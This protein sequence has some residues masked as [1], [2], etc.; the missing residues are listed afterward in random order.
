[1]QIL[2]NQNQKKIIQLLSEN[3]NQVLP[4]QS[5][6]DTIGVTARTLRTE[7]KKINDAI[8]ETLIISNNRGYQLKYT[9]LSGFSFVDADLSRNSQILFYLLDH[10]Q[11]EIDD[12]AETIYMS[13]S[14]LIQQ[15]PE[16]SREL[17]PLDL[18]LERRKN[19]LTVAGTEGNLRDLLISLLYKRLSS[20]IYDMDALSQ[21]C[22][23]IDAR[24]LQQTLHIVLEAHQYQA[25]GIYGMNLNLNLTVSFSRMIKGFRSD[26]FAHDV[27]M[28]TEEYHI[29]E[30]F[31]NRVAEFY[32]ISLCREDYNYV[33]VLMIGQ[34]KPKAGWRTL[35]GE[36]SSVFLNETRTVLESA[37]QYLNL[38]IDVSD[39]Q[40]E[41]SDYVYFMM[42]RCRIKNYAANQLAA[43][44]RINCPFLYD[45]AVRVAHEYR[46]R[47]SIEPDDAEIALLMVHM[48]KAVEQYRNQKKRLGVLLI[49]EA[50][51]DSVKEE[52]ARLISEKYK[53]SVEKVNVSSFYQVETMERQPD[54]IISTI[55]RVMPG[56]NIVNIT[57]LLLLSDELKLNEKIR[58]ILEEQRKKHLSASMRRYMKKTVF[59]KNVSCSTEKEAVEVMSE[60]GGFSNCAR[61]VEDILERESLS[62]TCLES[63][64]ALPHAVNETEQETGC[65]I[66]LNNTPIMWRQVP[67]KLV[68]L[69]SIARSDYLNFSEVYDNLAAYLRNPENRSRLFVTESADQLCSDMIRQM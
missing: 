25:H 16:L 61:L 22:G 42:K 58:Q 9:D 10:P 17:A 23:N 38:Q 18:K 12:V 55:P 6:A 1:M 44:L 57:P 31:C 27:N 59:L 41:F 66:L 29:A 28:D 45:V 69:F 3:E 39:I 49:C 15:F 62:S 60:Y 53:T 67:I 33:T 46:C 32:S 30:E 14:A 51:N 24:I 20:R 26:C 13:T 11:A 7:I 64:F 36:K 54:I 40:E 35:A 50:Y 65:C 37:F 47:Y 68:I 43:N 21:S 2:L 56:K 19:R 8:G 63:S 34:V 5:I 48:G 4:G 52:L